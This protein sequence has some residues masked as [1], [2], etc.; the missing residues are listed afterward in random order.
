[1][2]IGERARGLRWTEDER[3]VERGGG[4]ETEFEEGIEKWKAER[5]D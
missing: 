3:I 1:M 5:G 2:Y 4:R